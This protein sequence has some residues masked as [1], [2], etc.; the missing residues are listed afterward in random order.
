MPTFRLK[1]KEVHAFRFC[2]SDAPVWVLSAIANKQATLFQGMGSMPSFLYLKADAQVM[3]AR[4][5]DWVI[6]TCR[7]AMKVMS[8]ADFRETYERV[9]EGAECE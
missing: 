1:P 8:D 6:R 4:E 5:G 3:T 9:E 2:H 7:G